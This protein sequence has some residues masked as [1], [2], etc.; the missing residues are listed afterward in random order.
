[1]KMVFIRL[2]NF[3]KELKD[4]VVQT[5]VELVV[6][7]VFFIAAVVSFSQNQEIDNW[8][9]SFP[10]C[11]SLVHAVN[12]SLVRGLYYLS[13]LSI[14]AFERWSME[15]DSS[16]YWI[17]LVI[18]QLIV[19]LSVKQNDNKSFVENAL[20]YAG[21]L[22]GAILLSLLGWL[23]TWGIYRSVVYIFDL[24][25]ADHFMNYAALT[26]FF[27]MAPLLFLMFHARRKEGFKVNAFFGVLINFIVSPALLIYNLIL[28]I[29]ILK[30]VW[31][32]TLP[33]GGIAYLVL[34]FAALLGGSKAVQMVLRRRYYD[35][36][37]NYFSWWILPALVLL[38]I[39]AL[40][41]VGEYGWT[42]WRV[43]LMLM[44][45]I[46][47]ATTLLFFNSRWRKYKHVVGM[48]VGMFMLF[49]YIPGMNAEAWG[50]RSQENRMRKSIQFLY[51]QNG[52]R[53]TENTD[54]LS[55]KYYKTLQSSVYYVQ[56]FKTQE[57][58][59][60]H[61]GFTSENFFS[62]IPEKARNLIL[63]NEED[64]VFWLNLCSSQEFNITNFDSLLF[65]SPYP[66][67]DN[68]YY[69]VTD[70]Y[71]VVGRKQ[72][73]LLQ[74]DLNPLFRE[75]L[76]EN[77]IDTTGKLNRQKVEEMKSLFQE[78][79]LGDKKII[80]DNIRINADKVSIEDVDLRCLL[81][82]KK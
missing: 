69:S 41:R 62:L 13:V 82:R 28:Y 15:I 75:R 57:Y 16:I 45:L 12:R 68:L 80:L 77:G 74:V 49:T 76:V 20:G 35:W 44:V 63:G 37:Y 55:L 40:Q 43:Y 9:W 56:C 26:A 79:R 11:F 67:E 21:N 73:T 18:S 78:Y 17:T 46:V 61:F 6:S 19:L 59:L 34:S 33:K 32:W 38:W 58:M 31:V 25:V 27:L 36:Y 48:A 5:P 24:P 66:Q 30:I 39:S 70:G 51:I 53:W 71:L 8:L 54:S 10:A 72:D 29:Y 64:P 52:N 50:V 42:E 1:M 2:N 7:V 23:L 81:I 4:A 65:V 3:R 22:I 47:T 60:R 14:L